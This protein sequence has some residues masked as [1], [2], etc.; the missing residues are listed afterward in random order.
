M[1]FVLI[2]LEK[3]IDKADIKQV[4]PVM[5]KNFPLWELLKREKDVYCIE[6]AYYGTWGKGR[7]VSAG[8]PG[9]TLSLHMKDE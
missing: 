2:Q 4:M 6:R 8:I 7:M 5:Y 1:E 9:V 3:G